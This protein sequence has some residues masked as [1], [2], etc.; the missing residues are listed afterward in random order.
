MPID[1]WRGEGLVFFCTFEGLGNHQ[2]S[3]FSNFTSSNSKAWPQGGL[4][5]GVGGVGGGSWGGLVGGVGGGGEADTQFFYVKI[6]ELPIKLHIFKAA[7]TTGLLAH[8]DNG[9]FNKSI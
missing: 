4:E 3:M 1:E 7:Y 6:Q 8:N 5:R 2:V 9:M